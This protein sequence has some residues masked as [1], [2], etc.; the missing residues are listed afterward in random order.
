MI[1][2][3]Y[4]Q[5]LCKKVETLNSRGYSSAQFYYFHPEFNAELKKTITYNSKC[6]GISNY[7]IIIV[8][9]KK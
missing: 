4:V 8:L 1:T 9:F 6:C 3:N 7:F 2:K 5:L